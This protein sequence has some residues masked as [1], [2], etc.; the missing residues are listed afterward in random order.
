LDINGNRQV[1]WKNSNGHADLEED[2]HYEVET[3]FVNYVE[4]S[5]R[6][7]LHPVEKLKEYTATGRPEHIPS[8]VVLSRLVLENNIDHLDPALMD[9]WRDKLSQVLATWNR[10]STKQQLQSLFAQKAALSAPIDKIICI[11]LG[12]FHDLYHPGNIS[13]F[14]QYCAAVTIAEVLNQIDA[15]RNPHPRRVQIILQDP[16]FTQKDHM[17]LPLLLYAPHPVIV[18]NP[19]AFAKIDTHTFVFSRFVPIDVP[20]L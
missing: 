19:E 2:E 13:H 10:S 14:T 1:V 12:A 20:L 3:M 5:P 6:Y 15:M 17:L 8:P 9:S 11:D 16:V 18:D 7:D 4:I